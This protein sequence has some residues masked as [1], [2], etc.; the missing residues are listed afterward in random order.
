MIIFYRVCV[1]LIQEIHDLDCE[2]VPNQVKEADNANKTYSGWLFE[3]IDTILD[4][5]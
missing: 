3:F 4:Y 1:E 2:N 5:V